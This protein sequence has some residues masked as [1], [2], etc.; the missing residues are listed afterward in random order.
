MLIPGRD[1]ISLD[2][3][4]G[5]EQTGQFVRVAVGHDDTDLPLRRGIFKGNAK[6]KMD[7]KVSVKAF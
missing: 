5:Q 3:T 1:W 7:V 6:E 2:P 4:Q